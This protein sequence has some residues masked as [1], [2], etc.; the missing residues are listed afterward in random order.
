MVFYSEIF[1]GRECEQFAFVYDNMLKYHSKWQ[2]LSLKDIYSTQLN[3]SYKICSRYLPADIKCCFICLT[4]TLLELIAILVYNQASL[5]RLYPFGWP[6]SCAHLD[7]PKL[8]MDGS[9]KK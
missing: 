2:R 8:I 5:T 4:Y 3:N 9:K 6:T 1:F 7:V